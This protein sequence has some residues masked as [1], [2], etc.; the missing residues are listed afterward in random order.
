MEE[1]DK[2][3]LQRSKEELDQMI[4]LQITSVITSISSMDL[5]Q[6]F[7]MELILKTLEL[8]LKTQEPT[9]KELTFQVI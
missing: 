2:I 7:N 1:V 3:L 4:Q 6:E 8:I 9:I 5:L